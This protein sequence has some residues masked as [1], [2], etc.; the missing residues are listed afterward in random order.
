MAREIGQPSLYYFYQWASNHVHTTRLAL[1]AR[2]RDRDDGWLEVRVTG[3]N[4][5]TWL[6][7]AVFAG[8]LFMLGH[9]AACGL[10][11]WHTLDSVEAFR[12][13]AHAQM[14]RVLSDIGVPRDRNPLAD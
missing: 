1:D 2:T 13:H 4:T 10:L 11:G 8:E 9:V 7:V 3:A 6:G 5:Q 12:Q 14:R